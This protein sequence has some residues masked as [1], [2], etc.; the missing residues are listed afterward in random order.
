MRLDTQS[1]DWSILY[2]VNLQTHK[3]ISAI[4]RND[5]KL[6]SYKLALVRAINDIVLAYPDVKPHDNGVAIPLRF[7]ADFW[8][9]YYWSFMDAENPIYQGPRT[10]KNGV[11]QQDMGFRESLTNL[12]LEWQKIVGTIAV[13]S[14]G[15]VVSNEMKV[16]RKRVTY[17]QGFLELYDTTI[18]KIIKA[19]ENPIRYTGEGEWTTFQKP[20]ILSKLLPIAV[21]P[22]ALSNDKCLVVSTQLW[23]IFKD[24]SLW[25][26]AL[27]IQQWAIFCEAVNKSKNTGKKVSRGAIFELL[28]DKSEGRKSLSWERNN[29]NILILEGGQFI[30]PWTEKIIKTTKYDLDHLIPVSAYPINELWNLVPSDSYYNSHNKR[31]RLP[32]SAKMAKATS[33]LSDTYKTYLSSKTMSPILQEDVTLRFSTVDFSQLSVENE[34]ARVTSD[35]ILKIAEARNVPRFD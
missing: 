20:N 23:A 31:D 28:T 17:P 18:T 30:C 35:F 14:D 3:I 21:L 2:I 9:A 4:L 32:S 12:R 22:N 24:I 15:F 7:L 11:K 34:I 10:E 33:I 6:T 25:V 16:K 1:Y 8:L 26:E 13:T 29:I 19:I 27:C 5:K